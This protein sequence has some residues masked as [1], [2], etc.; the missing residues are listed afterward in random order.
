MRFHRRANLYHA[1]GFEAPGGFA[2]PDTKL[3]S[4]IGIYLY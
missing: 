3:M 4:N 2:S 1:L